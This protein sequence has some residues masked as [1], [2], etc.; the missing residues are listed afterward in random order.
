MKC[1]TRDRRGADGAGVIRLLAGAVVAAVL[2]TGCGSDDD[3]GSVTGGSTTTTNALGS[4]TT[5]GGSNSAANDRCPLTAEQ[6]STAL[7]ATVDKDEA[8]CTFYPK[9]D[10]SNTPNASFNLQLD[11]ACDSG[12]PAEAGYNQKLD[13]LG[14]DGYVQPDT[15]VGT[16]ILACAKPPFEVTVDKGSDSAGELE[17]AKQLAKKVLGSA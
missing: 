14:V 2:L 11:L 15:A 10:Y 13:G 4:S 12:G 16:M 6:V 5:A 9:D 17:A 1:T 7:G 3:E 8:A